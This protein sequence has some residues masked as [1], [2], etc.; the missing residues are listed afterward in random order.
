M[1]P[2]GAP[3]SVGEGPGEGLYVRYYLTSS[4]LTLCSTVNVGWPQKAAG[5]AE[6]LHAFQRIVMPI[7]LEF[8]PELV[9]SGSGP[10]QNA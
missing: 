6:Y 8:S 10:G 9:I 4:V 2:A 5:D 7:A 1:G 3:E